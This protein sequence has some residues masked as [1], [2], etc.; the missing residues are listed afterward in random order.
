MFIYLFTRR[1]QNGTFFDRWRSDV[2]QQ[3]FLRKYLFYIFYNKSQKRGKL[4]NQ[5]LI[6]MFN[7]MFN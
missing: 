6:L 4:L 2:D 3:K 7:A 1:K 5:A